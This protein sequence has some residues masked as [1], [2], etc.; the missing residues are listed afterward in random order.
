MASRQV[1]HVR[2]FVASVF[3]GGIS[4]LLAASMTQLW[5]AALLI[6]LLGVFAGAIYVLGFT[7]LQL[8]VDVE[9]RGRIFAAVYTIVRLSLIVARS[10]GPFVAVL[11]NGLSE[12]FFGKSLSIFGWE[13][14]IPG[15]RITLWIAALIIIGAGLLT[16][17][18]VRDL[19]AAERH[20][21]GN[22]GTVEATSERA[23]RR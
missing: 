3:G 4:L 20:G 16:W 15:V 10:V 11:L 7:L 17:A 8:S 13:V 22:D 19:L 14:F 5:A 23:D 18:S 12:E 1:G 6:G 9:L 21:D 2:I